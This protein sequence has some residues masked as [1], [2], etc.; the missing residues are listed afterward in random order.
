MAAVATIFSLIGVLNELDGSESS[1]STTRNTCM[2]VQRCDLV[3]QVLGDP[4]VTPRC[5]VVL[6]LFLLRPG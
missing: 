5:L 4:R 2:A 3:K 6:C 1:T